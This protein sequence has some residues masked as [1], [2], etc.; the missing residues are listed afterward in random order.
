MKGSAFAGWFPQPQD[1]GEEDQD[2]ESDLEEEEVD[3]DVVGGV[4]IEQLSHLLDRPVHGDPSARPWCTAD[5]TTA[6][7]GLKGDLIFQHVETTY[8]IDYG[9][10]RPIVRIYGRTQGGNSVMA[11]TDT[12]RPYFYARISSAEEAHRIRLALED[13]FVRTDKRALSKDKREY[14]KKQR[15]GLEDDD[16]DDNAKDDTFRFVLAVERVEKRSMCGWHREKPLESMHRFVMAYPSHVKTAR[17]SLEYANPAITTRPIDTFEANVPFELRFMVDTTLAGCQWVRLPA[18]SYADSE[19]S[20]QICVRMDHTKMQPIDVKEKGD[21]APMRMLSFD[22]EAKRKRQGFCKGEEDPCVCICAALQVGNVIVHKVA[23]M[24]VDDPRQQSVVAVEGADHVFAYGSEIDML[25]AFVHYI[26]ESDPDAF[27]GWNITGFDWP[28]LVKRA[29]ALGIYK[30]FLSFTR[31]DGKQAWLRE[32]TF[33]SKAYGAKRTNELL[34]EGRFN[35]DAL[36]F[37]LRGQMNKFRSYRLNAIA[38]ELLND[39]KVDV[40][41][42]QIPVLHEGSDLDRARLAY[43]CLKD[44]LLPLAILENRMALV[45]GIE[46]SRVTGVPLKWLL[47][48][49]QGIK[50]HSC[51]LRYKQP[52]EL[53]PSRS[54]KQNNVF[55]AGG[56]VRTPISG[57]YRYPLATLDYTSLYP[58]IMQ[59]YN[60]CYSTVESLEWARKNLQPGDYSIPPP[61]EDGG[62]PVD[63]CFVKPHIRLGVLPALLTSLL[64]QRNYVKALLKKVDKTR[65]KD[66]YDVLDGR[67]LALKVVCNSVYGFLKAFTLTDARL[68]SAVTSWGRMMIQKSASIVETRYHQHSIVDRVACEALGLN[69]ETEPEQGQLDPRPRKLYDA[70]IIYG[71]TDSIMIDFGDAPLQDIARYAREAAA[72][73]TAAMEPPNSLAPESLKLR[74]LYFRAKMYCSLEILMGD[75]KSGMTMAQAV[76]KAKVSYKGMKSKRR[77]NAPIASE[78]QQ[79]VLKAVL[80]K[81]DVKSAFDAVITALTNLLTNRTDMSQLVITKGLS[82]TDAQYEQGGTKQQHTELKKRISARAKY[83]GEIVPETGDRMP[84]IMKAGFEKSDKACDL[85]EDPIYAMEHGVPIN[86]SY[87]IKKQIL[88][89][90]LG[91]FTCIWEPDKLHCISSSMSKKVLRTLRA[92]Q[93][94]FAPSL[95]HMRVQV[96]VKSRGYGISAHTKPL[97]TCAA[98]K[99]GVLMTGNERSHVVCD[100]HDRS[101]A[102]QELDVVR[103]TKASDNAAA[104]DRCNVCAG[105]AFDVRQCSNIVCDNFFHRRKTETELRDIEDLVARFE[106]PEKEAPAESR[107]RR[108]I[109]KVA[110]AGG[111]E[112]WRAKLEA[113]RKLKKK[114]KR[115]PTRKK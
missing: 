64:N 30:Q 106:L 48:R 108:V 67:Q 41:Y 34:C 5:V 83:T 97:L 4:A 15:L 94:L 53:M 6:T 45:N 2:N 112:A 47:E 88:P 55:T 86:I 87:Y 57:H 93:E 36:I 11:W 44:A 60:I 104:W 62:E 77:D 107:V 3:D 1:E 111:E 40:S 31:L 90:V 59:A 76:E 42:T 49:G 26:R 66:L 99:C 65:D 109:D 9:S 54:P 38:K 100:S 24:Y 12:F 72:L 110:E 25:L 78:T 16:D 115:G 13:M 74:S 102:Q 17:N 27:T 43:Y 63:F 98:P 79:A 82:K 52:W 37:M 89:A 46:Q 69:Y 114:K 35:F 92:Y 75:I 20:A 32:Q 101:M 70:R 21:L 58:S 73:C 95:P 22:I 81:D 51:I 71:D 113:E 18:G 23:F 14:K 80:K 50:T 19:G 10:R 105:N 29:A 84:F 91:V 96:N 61:A 8:A 39:S 7:T 85:S 28:Y 103:V 56:H 68:M 33:Q